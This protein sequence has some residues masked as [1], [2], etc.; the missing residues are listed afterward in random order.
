MDVPIWTSFK[1]SATGHLTVPLHISGTVK[2]VEQ[3]D[4]NIWE[5]KDPYFCHA[6]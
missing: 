2:Q 6:T 4:M 5:W 3:I 1:A